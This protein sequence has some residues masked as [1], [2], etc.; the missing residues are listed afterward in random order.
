MMRPQTLAPERTAA[1]P[2][3]ALR[4]MLHRNFAPYFAGN[5]LSMCGTWF[6]TLA[7][8]ILV[9]RL[10][11][12]AFLV[13]VVNFALFAGVF[14]MAPWS[15]AAAD[16]YDRR[17]L[18]A[19][20]QAIAAVVT[21]TLAVV[22]YLG[23]ATTWVVV[24][25]AFLLGFS[26][27]FAIPARQSFIPSLVSRSELPAAVAL[28]SVTFN[29]ARTI[30]PVVAALIVDRYGVAAAF[31]FNSLSYLVLIAALYVV[32]PSPQGE[33]PAE[34]PRLRQTVKMLR[35]DHRLV[36]L[37][38]VVVI[39]S[40][41]SDPVSTLMP[42][43]ATRV[44]SRP[45]TLAGML[46]G[47]FGAGAVTAAFIFGA[48]AHPSYRRLGLTMGLLGGGMTLL[49]LTENLTLA[50]TGLFVAGFGFLATMTAATA[51][52]QLEVEDHQRGRVMALWSVA[53]LG[54][55]PVAALVDG[56]VATG[57]GVQAGALVMALPALVAAAALLLSH[58]RPLDRIWTRGVQP[59]VTEEI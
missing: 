7:Q 24:G 11:G 53:F 39:V 55:R 59:A 10:T 19:T 33:R 48:R 46:I 5:F 41:A 14:I 16:R 9:Y 58:E 52:L 1:G 28:N 21:G 31:G 29:L 56:A 27:A 23:L 54:V 2:R 47:I 40:V 51:T 18:L 13:G 50:M 6:Q 30:G 44:F 12:S 43:F 26:T 20:T 34:P 57:L 35:D 38:A 15:G 22:A 4:V 45:D 37:F 49:A 42:A 8:T 36:T 32:R 25:L 17:R 3:A